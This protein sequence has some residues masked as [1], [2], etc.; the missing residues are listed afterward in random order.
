MLAIIVSMLP[1]RGSGLFCCYGAIY[2]R[3][4]IVMSVAVVRRIRKSMRD[5][6]RLGK[7]QYKHY[8]SRY[9]FHVVNLKFLS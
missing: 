1:R 7:Y 6:Y 3:S 2:D 4:S 5:T 9:L 8:K